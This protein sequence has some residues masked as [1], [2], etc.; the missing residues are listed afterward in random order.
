MI[1]KSAGEHADWK[2]VDAAMIQAAAMAKEVAPY[3]HQRLAA[4]RL[5]GELKANPTEG[6][7]DELLERIKVELTKLGPIIE[8]DV[9]PGQQASRTRAA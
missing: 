5:A 7:L 9:A 1:E 8:L 2:A 3:R 4:L 6:T